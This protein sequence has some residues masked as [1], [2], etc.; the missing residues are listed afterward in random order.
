MN[1]FYNAI[2]ASL[3]VMTPPMS[4]HPNTGMQIWIAQEA[5]EVPDPRSL[6]YDEVF[7]L[8]EL[9]ES[10]SFEERCSLEQLEQINYLISMLAIQGAKEGNRCDVEHSIASLSMPGSG[11]SYEIFLCKSWVK[12][13]WEHTKKFVKKHKKEIIIGAIVVV[14][15]VVVVVAASAIASSVAAGAAA[16]GA[17]AAGDSKEKDRKPLSE[18]PPAESLHSSLDDQISAFRE[19]VADEQLEAGGGLSPEENG[20]IMGSMFTH[21]MV[22]ILENQAKENPLLAYDLRN[23][24]MDSPYLRTPEWMPSSNPSP[25][26]SADHAFSTNYAPFWKESGMD[27]NT[28]I[29]Q[30]RG[31]WAL[32]SGSYSQALH[33]FD[34][35]IEAGNKDAYL[36]RGVAHLGLGKY[37][38]SIS[39][40]QAYA[41]QTK[42]SFSTVD[43]SVGFAKGLPKGVYESGEG[44]LMFVTDLATHPIQTGGAVYDAISQLSHLAKAGEWEVIAESLSPELHQLVSQWDSLSDKERGELSGYA[45]GKHGSD[46]LL[47]GATAKLAAKGCTAAKELAAVCNNLKTAE[48]VLAFEAITEGGVAGVNVPERMMTT[49]NT[50]TMGEDLGLPVKEIGALKQSG[51]LERITGKGRDFFAGNPEMQASYDLFRNAQTTLKPY[52]KKPMSEVEARSLIHQ[53]GVKTLPKPAGIPEDYA[54]IISEKGAGMIYVHPNDSTTSV[55]V[56]PGKPH[57]PLPHQQQP[58]VI[59]MKDGEVLDKFGN[60]VKDTSPEAHIAYEEFVYRD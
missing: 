35:A 22:D 49:K 1:Y 45:F 47:P 39:D 18:T 60:I 46:I 53:T 33:D 4:A 37:E 17:A 28:L 41:S 19:N 27:L 55:R 29:Y 10:D 30:A 20:R 44:M 25:H 51:E 58:Y 36:G 3:I 23:I 56:M 50:L 52:T 59:Q 15:A 14:A 48:R 21:N 32:S 5:F 6:S 11:T 31:E 43:F 13:Q 2:L 8:L 42:Q 40:Y 26:I 54:I 12:K 24:G 38:E 7:D 16:S 57:S 9:I 34:R